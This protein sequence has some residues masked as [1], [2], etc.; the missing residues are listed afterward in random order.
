MVEGFSFFF[1]SEVD[2]FFYVVFFRNFVIFCKYCFYVVVDFENSFF[3]GFFIV[4][5]F[6]GKFDYCNVV[7]DVKGVW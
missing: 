4:Y 6:F 1:I 7:Y 3:N 5:E 2:K